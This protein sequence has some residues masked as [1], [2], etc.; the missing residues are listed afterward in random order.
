MIVALGALTFLIFRTPRKDFQQAISGIEWSWAVIACLTYMLSQALLA[1]R[2]IP[3]LKVQGVHISLWQAVRLTF[4]GLFYNNFMPG[5]VGGDLLKGWYITHHGEKH[6][7]VG[8]AVTV[9]V[10]R[11]VGLIGIILVAGVASLFAGSEIAYNDIQIR[12]LI[13]AIMGMMIVSGSVFLSHKIRRALLIG[14]LLEKLPFHKFLV[15]IDQAIQIY[16]HQIRVIML[17]LLLT[18]LIQGIAIFAVWMLTRA[19]KLDDVTFFDCL[20]IMPII[21]VIS[22]AIPVP[23]GIGIIENGFIYFF[24]LVINSENPAAAKGGA[25]ALALLNRIMICISSLPGALVPVFGGHLPR[26]KDLLQGAERKEATETQDFKTDNT[27]VEN[28]GSSSP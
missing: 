23:G 1:L 22:A 2:W 20:I 3:L 11:L 6:Q 5:A 19:L 12:W 28:P 13:W 4:L 24:M 18:A 26:H 7:R 14:H 21:W 15:K 10:D 16:R 9:F 17:S 25:A 27:T 8:A